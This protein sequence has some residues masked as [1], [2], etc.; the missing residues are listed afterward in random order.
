MIFTQRRINVDAG[1]QRAYGTFKTN[2][3]NVDANFDIMRRS[4]NIMHPLRRLRYEKK[5][6]STN[7]NIT[8]TRLFKD[9]E[10]LT[11]KN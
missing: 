9:I 2:L 6:Y 5:I 1:I 10:I 8:K 7:I 3:I 11:T 4:M